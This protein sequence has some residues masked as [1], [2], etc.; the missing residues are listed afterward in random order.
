MGFF[1][2]SQSPP[3][4]AHAGAFFSN[5]VRPEPRE[6]DHEGACRLFHQELT[7]WISPQ[8]AKLDAGLLRVTGGLTD[9]VLALGSNGY[10]S[11]GEQAIFKAGDMLTLDVEGSDEVAPASATITAPP[12]PIVAPPPGTIDTSQDLTFT[13]ESKA[14]TGTVTIGVGGYWPA[15]KNDFGEAWYPRDNVSCAA[16]VSQGTLTMPASL[17]SQITTDGA[18]GV[19]FSA[20][21]WNN[22]IRYDGDS[23]VG[24]LVSATAVTPSG[25]AYSFDAKLK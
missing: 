11:T 10:N 19:R 25:Q 20:Q 14:G 17:L 6:V 5:E 3:D 21:A 18:H 16:D 4:Q 8:P 12:V 9:V 15:V 24:F 22:E 7:D 2:I 23:R 1:A 13:W